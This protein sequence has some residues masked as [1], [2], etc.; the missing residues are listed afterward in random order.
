MDKCALI[1]IGLIM[2]VLP[3]GAWGVD[4]QQEPNGPG[5]TIVTQ[6]PVKYSPA[7]GPIL[8]VE[9]I[10]TALES[11][12]LFK[13]D[14]KDRCGTDV[15]L[16][17]QDQYQHILQGPGEGNGHNLFWWNLT[18]DQRLWKGGKLIFKARGS[19]TDGT[20]P[21]GISPLVGSKLNLDWAAYETTEAYIANVY[22]EQRLLDDRLMLAVGKITFP[23]YFDENKVAGW[24][25]FS[26]S[27]VR[28]QLFP[29]RYHTIGALARY[30]LTD[31]LY[32]QTGMTDADGIRS[33]SGLKTTFDGDGDLI[34][35]G[36]TGFKAKDGHGLE[37]NYRLETWYDTRPLN[38]H[39]GTGTQEG[40]LGF[41]VN[42]DHMLT[43]RIGAFFRYGID[44]GEVRTFSHYWSAGGTWKG[45]L[46]GRS[47][48]VLALGIGQGL[49][50]H[51]YRIANGST[52]SEMILETYYKIQWTRFLS[53]LVDCQVLFNPG[54][55]PANE[56]A[57][58]PGMR[59]KAVF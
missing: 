43:D 33:H 37:G 22:I 9:R 10:P 12:R 27:L 49:T 2:A 44:D 55:N 26:H 3:L 25:F 32:I 39:D 50:S 11:W 35:M 24:D 36:E 5:S 46:E 45:P 51:D 54:T 28:N 23:N 42:L 1:V 52:R 21:N 18:I 4:P 17:L 20:P 34:Y 15:G 41:G 19:N 8:P 6:P 40:T 47:D 58:I 38:R 29:H 13:K 53:F 7:E 48:D 16:V 59:L 30:D 57:V 56:T 14:L 31:R